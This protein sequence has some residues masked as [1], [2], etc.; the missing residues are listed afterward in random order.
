MTGCTPLQREGTR[1]WQ[2]TPGALRQ[3]GLTTKQA[4][5]RLFRVLRGVGYSREE[6]AALLLHHGCW[7]LASDSPRFRHFIESECRREVAA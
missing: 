5:V 1:L 4:T 3:R 6:S 7:G 2:A